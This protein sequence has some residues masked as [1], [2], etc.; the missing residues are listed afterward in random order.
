MRLLWLPAEDTFK[1]TL[2]INPKVAATTKRQILGQIAGIFDP[3]GILGSVI[4]TAKLVIQE[5]WKN[6]LDWNENAPDE[7]SNAWNQWREVKN[8]QIPR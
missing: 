6:K 5:L 7:I 2:N 1:F 8:I 3:L 4:T